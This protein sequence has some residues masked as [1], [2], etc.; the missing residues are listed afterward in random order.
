MEIRGKRTMEDIDE[1]R[2]RDIDEKRRAGLERLAKEGYTITYGW[3]Q[4]LDSEVETNADQANAPYGYDVATTLLDFELDEL[5]L[6]LGTL[7]RRGNR[8]RWFDHPYILEKGGVKTYV[9]EPYHFGGE[10]WGEMAKLADG[11]WE[12]E[13]MGAEYAVHNPGR[14]IVIWIWKRKEIG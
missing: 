2:R 14:T 1:K 13:I 8:P 4:H 5:G 6:S 7:N 9:I 3:L 12:V 11:G 10:S